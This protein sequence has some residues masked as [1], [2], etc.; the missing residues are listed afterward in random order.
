MAGAT[1]HLGER[2]TSSIALILHELAINAAKYGALSV[3]DGSVRITW[4]VTQGN[5]NLQWWEDNGPEIR[6][7][8][9]KGFGSTL[10]EATIEGLGGTL[11]RSWL[12]HGLTIHMKVPMDQ[13]TR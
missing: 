12:R 1:I 13:L 8:T 6:P 5:L 7:P 4:E 3:D 10:L 11:N 2:A 9:K